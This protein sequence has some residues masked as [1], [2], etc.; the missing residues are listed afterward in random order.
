MTKTSLL[1]R[2]GVKVAWAGHVSRHRTFMWVKTLSFVFTSQ[3][4]SICCRRIEMGL[5]GM[6]RHGSMKLMPG[7]AMYLNAPHRSTIWK[8]KS[9]KYASHAGGREGRKESALDRR[10]ERRGRQSLHA[11]QT[12]LTLTEPVS[13]VVQQHAMLQA[14]YGG[15]RDRRVQ[16]VQPACS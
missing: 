8:K 7:P 3:A 15:R 2:V 13:T 16:A 11:C 14:A 12:S 1:R 6:S 10:N 5:V 9:S 4:T